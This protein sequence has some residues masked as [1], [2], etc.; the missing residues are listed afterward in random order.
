MSINV[1]LKKLVV[2]IGLVVVVCAGIW[3][4][5]STRESRI[6]RAEF[7]Q[8][9]SFAERQAVEIA[10]IEQSFKLKQYRQAMVKQ[11]KVQ[12]PVVAESAKPKEAE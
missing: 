1:N 2:M 5:E 10:V 6:A 9:V 11:E 12:L 7:K 8:L 3:W 4:F